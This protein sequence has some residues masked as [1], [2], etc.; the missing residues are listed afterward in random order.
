M[1]KVESGKIWKLHADSD[2]QLLSLLLPI[3]QEKEE[4]KKRGKKKRKEKKKG[5]DSEG[6]LILPRSN[7]FPA[8]KHPSTRLSPILP[9]SHLFLQFHF[10][11]N[12]I[13]SFSLSLFSLSLSLSCP[14]WQRLP[15]PSRV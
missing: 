10:I 5:S 2:R 3:P 4:E 7:H 8:A 15:E 12:F 1:W 14:S 6:T 11:H 9:T 13:T